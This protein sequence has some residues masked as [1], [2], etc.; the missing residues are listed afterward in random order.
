V[1]SDAET[2]SRYRSNTNLESISDALTKALLGIGLT[3][4]HQVGD[5]VTIVTTKLGPSFGVAPAGGIVAVCVLIYGAS[6][7]FLFGYLAT[8]VYLTGVFMRNELPYQPPG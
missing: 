2:P 1:G 4:L 8:R 6:E 7:G 5:A 3:Q